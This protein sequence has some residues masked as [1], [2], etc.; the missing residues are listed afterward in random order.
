MTAVFYSTFIIR[1]TVYVGYDPR[2]FGV[3]PS[4]FLLF[5]P[6]WRKPMKN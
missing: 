3:T 2:T 5:S 6:S 1:K 4:R